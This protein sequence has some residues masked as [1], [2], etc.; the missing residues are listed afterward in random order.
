MRLSS[1]AG[2]L[3]LATKNPCAKGEQ[4]GSAVCV[5][6]GLVID[7]GPV[8]EGNTGPDATSAV[9]VLVSVAC[10]AVGLLLGGGGAVPKADCRSME[11]RRP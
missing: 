8:A 3:N 2:S 1:E 9:G 4:L 10:R 7:C 5:L 11:D 6:L